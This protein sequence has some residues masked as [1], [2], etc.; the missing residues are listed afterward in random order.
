[1]RWC[2]QILATTVEHG[3]SKETE[4]FG[5]VA[6]SFDPKSVKTNNTGDGVMTSFCPFRSFSV[7]RERLEGDDERL[8]VMEPNLRLEKFPSPAGIET[9]PHDQQASAYPTEIWGSLQMEM[10]WDHKIV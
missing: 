9:R 10:R 1:M 4:L 5:P 6:R 8:Y 2:L 7:K 3:C